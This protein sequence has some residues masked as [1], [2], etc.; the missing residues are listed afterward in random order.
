MSRVNWMAIMAGGLLTC[1]AGCE[2]TLPATVSGT[3]TIDGQPL[4]GHIAGEVM[5]HP[6]GGGAAA[7]APLESD[8]GFTVSTGSTKGL[9]P[10]TYDVTVRVA[11][12][13]P[14]PP[15]GYESAPA[16]RPL[17]PGRYGIRDKSGLSADVKE[18]KNEFNFDL[19]SK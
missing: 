12:T 17:S 7:L 15:G 10:G 13:D 4:T 18:G 5:F 2:S 19:K 14:E 6:T 9:E 16:Q 3:I 8:G 11:E 1:F